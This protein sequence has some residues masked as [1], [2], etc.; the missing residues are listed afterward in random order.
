MQSFEEIGSDIKD[1]ACKG[2]FCS[3]VN[4]KIDHV[5]TEPTPTLDYIC[6]GSVELYTQRDCASFP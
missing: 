3:S 2:G 5:L 4:S 1:D 6:C